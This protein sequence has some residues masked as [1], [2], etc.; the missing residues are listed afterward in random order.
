MTPCV[1]LTFSASPPLKVPGGLQRLVNAVA[2]TTLRASAE[3][4]TVTRRISILYTPEFNK[5]RPPPGRS[6][7][8]CPERLDVCVR[9]LRAD[10]D[11]AD[12]LDWVTPQSVNEQLASDRRNFVLQAV[13]AVHRFP[14]YL[15][16]LASTCLRGGGGVDGDTYLSPDSFETALL[17]ASAWMEAV[18]IAMENKAK[19][20]WALTRPP[21]HHAT[22]ASGMGFCLLSNAAIAAK[23]ALEHKNASSVAILDFDVH[24]GNGTV[25]YRYTFHTTYSF[26]RLHI[27]TSFFTSVTSFELQEA[28]IRNDSRIRFASSHQWPLYPGSGP[29]GQT[30][31]HSNIL[32]INLER[33]TG[34]DTYR[35]R[36]ENEL[37]PFLL[38]SGKPDLF[39]VSAGFDALDVDPL[40]Q[41]NFK[42]RDYRLFTQLLLKEI[43]TDTPLVFGL[44][45]GYNLGE[46]GL[47]AAVT[48]TIAGYCL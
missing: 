45:G 20:A 1:P 27:L 33:G 5:H 48:E 46:N 34:I 17:A 10:P 31:P 30:G 15:D 3:T 28:S 47:G 8:E 44:E 2:T 7:P 6:H 19:A 18:D 22:P 26:Q 21:G 36:F 37:L 11:V 13:R 12:L 16:L 38:Q 39:I 4:T 25:S 35:E 29:E 32:N 9:A 43:G 42:P 24:H 41:L 14:D 40:A 23:Y